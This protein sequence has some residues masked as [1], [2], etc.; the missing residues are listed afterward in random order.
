MPKQATTQIPLTPEVVSEAILERLEAILKT[1]GGETGWARTEP[2][3]ASYGLIENVG[4]VALEE[5][6]YD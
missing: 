5:D 2:E 3:T 4:A 6:S 1:P